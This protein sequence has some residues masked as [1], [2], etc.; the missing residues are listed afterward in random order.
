[1]QN[2]SYYDSPT[3]KYLIPKNWMSQTKYSQAIDFPANNEMSGA[4]VI[5]L[6]SGTI[7]VLDVITKLYVSLKDAQHLPQA[8][9]EVNDRLPLARNTLRIAEERIK[10][11]PDTESCG[12][13]KPTVESCKGRAER[14]K[15]ILQEVALEPDASRLHRYRLAVR[16]FGKE[17]RVEELMKGMLEDVHLL[18]GNRAIKAATETQVGELL[19]AIQ[20]LSDVPPSVADEKNTSPT[21]AVFGNG[22]Q[23]NN[24]GEGVQNIHSGNGHQYFATT[25]DVGKN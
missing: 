12:A 4:E 17:S 11:I 7:T 15:N 14:L 9:R 10:V 13:M 18:A 23:F 8:F 5:G 6:I 24:T 3:S 16:R 2:S 21:F 1:M 22:H 25:I 19:K 20:E